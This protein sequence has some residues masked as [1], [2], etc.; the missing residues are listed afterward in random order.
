[1]TYLFV[2]LGVVAGLIGAFYA[3]SYW[4]SWRAR[5]RIEGEIE[6]IEKRCG[7]SD[8]EAGFVVHVANQNELN[9]PLTLYTSLQ[10]FDTLVGREV[11]LLMD[12]AAPVALKRATVALAYGARARLFPDSVWRPAP[13][14]PGAVGKPSNQ[15]GQGED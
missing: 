7:L 9:V 5:R 13:A 2:F 15:A 12:S 8:E 11:E 4:L 1:M 6:E 10:V 14:S 3:G